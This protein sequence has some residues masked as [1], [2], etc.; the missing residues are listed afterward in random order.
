MTVASVPAVSQSLTV[1]EAAVAGVQT[2]VVIAV[3]VAAAILAE[4]V[5]VA[6]GSRR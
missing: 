6:T 4:A 1:Q 3:A 5:A 2:A